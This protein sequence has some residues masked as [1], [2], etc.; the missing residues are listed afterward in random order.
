M[1]T[2]SGG[3]QQKSVVGKWLQVEPSVLL[4]HEPT[5][6]VDVEARADVFRILAEVVGGGAG[7]LLASSEFEDVARVCDRV[8]VF[9]RGAV[10]A[11][12]HGEGLTPELIADVSY[13]DPNERRS[14]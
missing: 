13:R 11:E 2:L 10:V 8:L 6:G 5:Q 12:L 9:Q 14:A 1:G 7:A 3:N 4:L